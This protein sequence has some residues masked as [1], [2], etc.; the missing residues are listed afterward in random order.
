MICGEWS[1]GEKKCVC[2]YSESCYHY[3]YYSEW[4]GNIHV[5][6]CKTCGT[7]IS[8]TATNKSISSTQHA[9]TCPDCGATTSPSS[10][11]SWSYVQTGYN[12]MKY[13]GSCNYGTSE[14]HK[15]PTTWTNG[16]KTCPCGYSVSCSH[17][18]YSYN[19]TGNKHVKTC[20]TCGVATEE[21]HSMSGYSSYSSSQ[22]KSSC[23]LCGYYTLSSHSLTTKKDSTGTYN[24]CSTCGYKSSYTHTHSSYS[25][26]YSSS[27][28]HTKSCV[29]C[30]YS[31]SESHSYSLKCRQN[32]GY[33]SR[34]A[35]GYCYMHGTSG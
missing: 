26:S 28:K 8:Y 25:Y 31:T 32:S 23:S 18:S 21:S 11:G 20:K 10:H 16:K 2:G 7:N 33:T 1:N 24:Y 13:C 14:D 12:H 22:H 5:H 35:C 27:S 34:C 4:H 15:L 30:G 3:S 19:Q 6:T 17:P 29:A 9:L